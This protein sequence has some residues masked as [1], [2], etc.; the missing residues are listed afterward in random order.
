MRRSWNTKGQAL[1]EFA[2]ILPIF[3][4]LLLGIFDFGRAIYAYNTVLNASR[5]GARH[6]IVDQTAANVRGAAAQ[7]A[8]ALG[9]DPADV[10]VDYRTAAAPNATGSCNGSV[11]T[12]TVVGCTAVVRVEYRYDAAT[13]LIGNLVGQ[14][15]VAGETRFPVEFA[16]PQPGHTDCPKGDTP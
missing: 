15:T 8:V 13:P 5:E 11:G 2:L 6:A 12:Q 4:L 1:V 3:V 16:C 10:D 7:H 9:I 14:I